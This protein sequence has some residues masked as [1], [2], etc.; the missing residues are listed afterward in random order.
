MFHRLGRDLALKREHATLHGTVRTEQP[1]E[2][3]IVVLVYSGD[4]GQ[5]EVADE[6][7]LAGPGPYFF[8][9][10][11]GV[12]RLAAFADLNRNFSYEPG[13]DAS[14]LLRAGEPIEAPGGATIHDLDIDIRE[15]SH[16]RMPLAVA[17]ADN[18]SLDD[19]GLQSFRLGEVTRLDD[20]RFSGENARRGLWQPFDFVAQVGAGVYFLEPYDPRKIPV[21]FV[22]GA[23]GN[24]GDWAALIASLD[25]QRF[26]PWLVYY[27]TAPRLETTA[28]W[29]DRW[30]QYLSVVH[31]YRQM[32]VV[33]HSM[34]GLV[35]RAFLNR[36]SAADDGRA[37]GLRLF[38]TL[39]TPWDGH[40]AAQRGVARAPVV[41]PSWYDMA[42]GSPFLRSLLDRPL[43]P[44]L[45]YD[46]LFS[47]AGG[48]RFVRA[49][50]DGAV[51]VA[52]QLDLR[53][54]AHTHQVRGFDATHSTILQSPEVAAL[55]NA[56][57]AAL[58]TE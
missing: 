44:T 33:A 31:G 45:A 52:S 48:S 20:P 11:A 36:L 16:A 21:L 22:H 14:A 54:Q 41:V 29:L 12:Y 56:Q 9:V 8:V 4:D 51:T 46:L 24:P 5:E 19:A 40:S 37:A 10:P 42:P 57:L 39:S 53:A 32:A 6:F 58:A 23:V 38:I 35:A 25:R 34:G 43:P 28:M 30:V 49:A 27:P 1:T 15:D 18:A 7:V 47:Y 50:N 26:Q 3:P 2:A 13:E 17:C 55:I